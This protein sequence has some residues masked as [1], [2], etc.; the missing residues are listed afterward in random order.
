MTIAFSVLAFGIPL[1]WS[2]A[3]YA[4]PLAIL[5]CLVFAPFALLA[6][7]GAIYAKQTQ[8]GIGFVMLRIAFVADFLFPVSCYRA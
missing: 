4:V 3:P 8:S 7:A 2:T 5:G 1:E 6:G